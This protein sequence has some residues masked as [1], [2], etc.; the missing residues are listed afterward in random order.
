MQA[1]TQN[2]TTL[3]FVCLGEIWRDITVIEFLMRC[4]I[5]KEDGD[6]N[7]LPKPP[8]TKGR[9]YMN[10]PKSFSHYSF[11]IVSAKFSKRFPKLDIPEELIHLRDA[12][13]HGLIS[14]VNNSGIIE[15]VKFK[16]N[17]GVGGLQI[18]FSMTLELPRL[19]Q[20]RQLLK[21]LRGYIMR[22]VDEGAIAASLTKE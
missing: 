20:I 5:A 3:F 12:M 7:L 10:Y 11:E 8:Y 4:A 19:L 18:E 2:E 22:E 6:I 17:D 1:M 15:L 13:A 14:E 9:V 16:E 21:E